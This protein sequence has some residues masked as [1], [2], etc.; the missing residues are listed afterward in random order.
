VLKLS[1]R[2]RRIPLVGALILPGLWLQKITTKKPDDSQ[3]EVAATAL[4]AVL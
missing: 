2:Y 3:L 1:D 4:K